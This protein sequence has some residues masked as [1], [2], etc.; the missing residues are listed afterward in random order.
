MADF[1]GEVE[2]TLPTLHQGQIKIW[3]TR[4]KYNAVA[5]GRRFGKTLML[6]TL[7]ADAAARGKQVGLFTPEH[8]QLSEPYDDLLM[9]LLPIRAKA[10]KTDGRIRT[11][12]GG[13]I[14]FWGLTDNE[15]AGR[16]RGYDL[17]LF[18]ETGQT[19]NGQTKQ[20]WLS[21]IRPTMLTHPGA[22]TWAFGT[23]RGVTPGNFFHQ[24]WNDPKLG[25]VRHHAPSAESP[26][27]TPEELEEHRRNN[28]PLIFAQEYLAE[29]VD[30]SGAAL[31]AKEKLLVDGEPVDYPRGCDSVFLVV[32][33]AVK[34]GREHDATAVSWWAFSTFGPYPLI[35]LDWALI[36]VDGALLEHI[37]PEWI[38]HG[39]ELARECRALR[40]C[41]GAY[42]E[43]VA[44]GSVLLQQCEIRSIPAEALP[45]K[46][47]AAGKDGRAINASGAVYRGQVKVSRVAYEKEV[48]YRGDTFNHFLSQVTGFRLGD[49][50]ADRRADDLLDTFTYAVAVACGGSDGWA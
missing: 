12:T 35:C 9:R 48:A 28:D 44:A 22:T 1:R 32:D 39:K 38:V 17:V 19:K 6:I 46:L 18:D 29:F 24:I 8:R 14:D 10:N 50:D 26:F 34:G 30:F 27:V 4:A 21:Q 5:C 33:T 42:I 11:I 20:F 13:G 7:A 47:T 2:I 40:G 37:V 16:G 3:E 15:L 36:Q 45:S 31:F 43:D 41:T 25:F 23:P 49:K